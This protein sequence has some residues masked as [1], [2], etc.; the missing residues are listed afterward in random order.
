MEQKNIHVHLNNFKNKLTF[1]L[2]L[3][4]FIY[5]FLIYIFF[6]FMISKVNTDNIEIENRNKLIDYNIKY[7]LPEKNIRGKSMTQLEN[8]EKK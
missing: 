5:L 1:G 6:M 4:Y 2:V 7:P 8:K 3:K